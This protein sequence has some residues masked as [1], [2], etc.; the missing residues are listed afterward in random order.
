MI[1]C[2]WEEWAF[3]LTMY[4]Y[5]VGTDLLHNFSIRNNKKYILKM[6]LLKSWKYYFIEKKYIKK[7]QSYKNIV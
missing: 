3:S 7:Q 5:D 2:N 1:D 6:Y 4:P